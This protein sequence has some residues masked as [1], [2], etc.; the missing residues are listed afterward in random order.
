MNLYLDLDDEKFEVAAHIVSMLEDGCWT[1]EEVVSNV[2]RELEGLD[3][4]GLES[5][6]DDNIAEKIR[7]EASYPAVTDCDRLF[8]A[9]EKLRASKILALHCPGSTGS[10]CYYQAMHEWKELGGMASKL[11]GSVYYNPQDVEAAREDGTLFISFI[12]F[13]QNL[14]EDSTAPASDEIKIGNALVAALQEEGLAVEWNGEASK[15]VQTMMHW[16][17]RFDAD[18][19]VAADPA[20]AAV[21]GI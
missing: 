19:F 3:A 12:A 14:Y 20:P 15:R 2:S 13:P 10:S 11:V 1:R 18:F 9:F 7:G 6:I 5:L 21:T 8:A 17:K 16:Q 4:A